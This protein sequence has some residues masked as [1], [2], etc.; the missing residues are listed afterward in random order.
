MRRA[1]LLVGVCL[2]LACPPLP[3]SGGNE[4]DGTYLPT[5]FVAADHAEM[6]CT[7]ICESLAQK[8][9]AGCWIGGEPGEMGGYVTEDCAGTNFSL[10]SCDDPVDAAVAT[11]VECCCVS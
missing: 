10:G 3:E 8:C 6:T 7:Q 1:V 5:C 4:N 11:S 2:L 9:A